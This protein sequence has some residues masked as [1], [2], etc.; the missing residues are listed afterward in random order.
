MYDVANMKH[1]NYIL[2]RAQAILQREDEKAAAL[3][4]AAGL[5]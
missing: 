5:P 3:N 4:S 1:V 2:E